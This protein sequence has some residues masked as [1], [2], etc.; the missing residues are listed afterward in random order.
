MVSAIAE[1]TEGEVLFRAPETLRGMNRYYRRM[2]RELER[3]DRM[4]P[5][6]AAVHRRTGRRAP[7]QLAMAP[8]A[9]RMQYALFSSA[10]AVC[11]VAYVAERAWVRHVRRA[12]RP[13]WP[14]VE[15]TKAW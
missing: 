15:E 8:F 10:L 11:R 3:L 14:P 9:E 5:E 12:P 6:T 1:T 7:D 13:A 2:R 4:F